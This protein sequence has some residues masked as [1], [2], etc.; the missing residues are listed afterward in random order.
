MVEGGQADQ[1][2]DGAAIDLSEFG[3]QRDERDCAD[4]LDAF[5]GLEQLHLGEEIGS[6]AHG[7]EDQ[8]IADVRSD[9]AADEGERACAVLRK[10]YDTPPADAAQRAKYMR[11]LQQRGFAH[12]AIQAAM[13]ALESPSE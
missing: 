3:Q 4:V 13:K 2:C 1:G 10:K 8:A 5:E 6:G 7:I 12:R 9:L 11:F